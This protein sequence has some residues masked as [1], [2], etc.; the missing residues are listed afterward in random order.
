M[1]S[2]NPEQKDAKNY[3]VLFLKERL[4]SVVIFSVLPLILVSSII[5]YQFK[6]SYYEK[7]YTHLDTLVKKHKL[8]I[9]TFLIEK[10]SDIRFI[11]DSYSLE[12]LSNPPFLEGKLKTLQ[13]IYGPVFVDLGVIDSEGKQLA[14]AG[15]FKLGAASYAEADW[16]E[17]AMESNY[18]ISDVFLGL[19]GFPHFIVTVR[20]YSNG[21]P[22][23]LRATI[24]FA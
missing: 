20:E 7:I 17:K 19:R 3:F 12:N 18:V 2:E 23:I 16:F 1:M 14:Y 8:H 13:N 6:T 4:L 10:L 5:L 24:D 21:R 15:P 22:W 9:D 11:A